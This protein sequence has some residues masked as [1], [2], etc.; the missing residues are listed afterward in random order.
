[1]KNGY[2][3]MGEKITTSSIIEYYIMSVQVWAWNIPYQYMLICSVILK[4]GLQHTKNGYENIRKKIYYKVHCPAVHIDSLSM[5]MK[6]SISIHANPFSYFE[7]QIT[8]Y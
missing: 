1:M 8:T 4:S 6:Y 5:S 3:N 2:E 7:M